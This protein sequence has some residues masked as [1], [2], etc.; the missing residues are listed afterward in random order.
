MENFTTK[1][2]ILIAKNLLF[3][4]FVESRKLCLKDLS[5]D[6]IRKLSEMLHA[7]KAA[8]GKFYQFFGLKMEGRYF[9]EAVKQMFPDT[10]VSVLK[11]CF[12]ALR[13]YDLVEFM[14]KVKPRCLRPAVSPEEIA[15]SRDDRPTKY[16]SDVAVLVVNHTVEEDTVE[17]ED[18]EKI[19]TFFNDLNSRNEVATI[20]LGTPR[21]TREFLRET[22]K[23]N[24]RIESFSFDED[25]HNMHLKSTLQEMERLEKE[26]EEVMQMEKGHE[27]RQSYQ[28]ERK[29]SQLKEEELWYRGKLEN[30]VKERAQVKR[31][32]EELKKE[33]VEPISTAMDELIHNQGWLIL[34][35]TNKRYNIINISLEII[36]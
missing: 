19:E 32:Y 33:S 26:L 1:K 6:V 20:S 31:Y 22:K 24:S 11:E 10:T 36:E 35:K 34:L 2:N 21:E 8:L 12:E 23:K 14:E 18:A 29:L 15:E 3:I 5:N 16:H 30:I 4:F 13:L 25:S 9:L 7:D 27:Q 28:L 17:R